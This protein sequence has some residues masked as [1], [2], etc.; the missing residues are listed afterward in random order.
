MN[1]KVGATYRPPAASCIKDYWAPMIGLVGQLA[2]RRL[3]AAFPWCLPMDWAFSLIASVGQLA[4]RW[5]HVALHRRSPMDWPFNS[6]R[7]AIE[8]KLKVRY[9]NNSHHHYS[10]SMIN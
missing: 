1:G 7:M 4:A 3:Q 9:I 2:A 8:V 6:H 5:P 10:I